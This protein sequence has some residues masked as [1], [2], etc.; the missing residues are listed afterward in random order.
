[1]ILRTSIKVGPSYICKNFVSKRF[2]HDNFLYHCSR[3]EPQ[4]LVTEDLLRGSGITDFSNLR[5]I[6]RVHLHLLLLTERRRVV[7]VS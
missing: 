6:N 3:P 1:M 7:Y 5:K 2:V 4:F